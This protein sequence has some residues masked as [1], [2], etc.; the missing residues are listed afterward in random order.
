MLC[1]FSYFFFFRLDFYTPSSHTFIKDYQLHCIFTLPIQFPPFLPYIIS[2]FNHRPIL[3][4]STAC[5][6]FLPTSL[7]SH[8]FLL[9][10]S[11]LSPVLHSIFILFTQTHLSSFSP[12]LTSIHSPSSSPPPFLTLLC[13]TNI[14]HRSLILHLIPVFILSPK[15]TSHLFLCHT[16]LHALIH[17]FP[18]PLL[19]PDPPPHPHPH[20]L[21]HGAPPSPFP[22]PP[23]PAHIITLHLHPS[24]PEPPAALQY[25]KGRE[26]AGERWEGRQVSRLIYGVLRH[27]GGGV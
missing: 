24:H 6:P 23:C 18:P 7:F 4:A 1:L 15:L 13:S 8:L 21:S 19:I 11:L 14:I 12:P 10:Y 25:T 22:P 3:L 26:R 20:N 9:L 5:L 16:H 17:T 2:H 27:M